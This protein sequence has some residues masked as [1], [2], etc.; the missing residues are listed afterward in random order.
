MVTRLR[1]LTFR[2]RTILTVRELSPNW[3]LDW[4][5]M[6]CRR[7]PL[8]LTKEQSLLLKNQI[9]GSQF[10]SQTNKQP[11]SQILIQKLPNKKNP[12]ATPLP[13]RPS[14]RLASKAPLLT[15]K[16]TSTVTLSSEYSISM[17]LPSRAASTLEEYGVTPATQQPCKITGNRWRNER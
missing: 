3:G 14:P 16:P 9:R 1:A 5:L 13:L 15:S 10:Q 4:E 11:K 8:S 2:M 12:W 17:I 7:V 6:I